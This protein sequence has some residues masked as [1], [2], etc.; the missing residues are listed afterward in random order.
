MTVCG[1]HSSLCWPWLLMTTLQVV[2]GQTGLELAAAVDSERSASRAAIKVTLLKQEQAGKPVS[3]EGVFAGASV[4]GSAEGKLMQAHP[5]SLC[6]TSDEESQDSIF[7]SIIKLE[8][9][10]HKIPSCLPLLEKARLALER[11]AQAVIFDV[12]DDVTA[13]DE[14]WGIDILPHP[15]VLVQAR[16]AEVLMSLV[17][18]NEEAMV[19]IEVLTELPKWPQYDLGILLIVVLAMMAFAMAF[20]FRFR[21]R[22][23]RSWDSVHQQTLRA[24]SHLETRRY[25]SQRHPGSR[26]LRG[27]LGAGAGSSPAPAC[28]ICLEDF[29]DG[30]DLRIISC[31]HEFH[32]ECVDPW[33]LQHRTCPLCMHNIMGKEMDACQAPL[34]RRQRNTSH[35]SGILHPHSSPGHHPLHQCPIPLPI[36][37]HHHPLGAYSSS[38]LGLQVMHCLPRMHL[39]LSQAH[40]SYHMPESGFL[41]GGH[42]GRGYLH[43]SCYICPGLCSAL[44][45]RPQPRPAH[46]GPHSQQE[47]GSCSGVSCD[48]EPSGYLPDG[49]ASDSSSGPCHSSSDNSVPNCT[50]ISL[51]GVYGSWST[52]RSSLSSDYDPWV[53]GGPPQVRTESQDRESRALSLDSMPVR[54]CTEERVFSHIHYHQHKHHHYSHSQGPEWVS[55]EDQRTAPDHGMDKDR[56]KEKGVQ[57]PK[58]DPR[59]TLNHRAEPE[60]DLTGLPA[61]SVNSQQAPPPCCCRHAPRYHQ[62]RRKISSLPENP[63]L[64]PHLGLDSLEDCN[65][66][67]H[68]STCTG[69]CPSL[70]SPSG[71]PMPFLLDTGSS[72]EWPHCGGHKMWL[73]CPPQ[74]QT[75]LQL[76]GPG[77]P[78]DR[79][80]CA[81]S[82]AQE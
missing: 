54:S 67:I 59:D 74:A 44:S 10:E 20:V 43:H 58:T 3:L 70:D 73:Q 12:T 1:L 4:R 32:K 63:A 33:L 52:S 82:E 68:Y 37:S 80:Q 14:L 16:N 26:R 49:P 7:I 41:T 35:N 2:F 39:G 36:P 56:I 71:L 78:Q 15:V 75:E 9:P 19:R 53:Y 8:S 25:S 57:F 77:Y 11:G 69:C 21:C 5:L 55:D 6:N 47:D 79:P 29:L 24:V 60:C 30:E 13:A 34:S 81:G 66:S 51:Q 23:K 27:D 17:N 61:E 76:Q 62:Q 50:D 40:C 22:S 48:T 45:T 65:R 64:R 28:A 38:L 42:V 18:K 46:A 31:A 72:G